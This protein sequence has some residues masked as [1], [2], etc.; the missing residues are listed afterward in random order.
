MRFP[1]VIYARSMGMPALFPL[2]NCEIT[3]CAGSAKK[4]KKA[5]NAKKAVRQNSAAKKVQQEA[6]QTKK[7]LPGS[8]TEQSQKQTQLSN[9]KV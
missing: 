9:T 8:T 2:R 5:K 1:S 4:A 3:A 7:G 6:A